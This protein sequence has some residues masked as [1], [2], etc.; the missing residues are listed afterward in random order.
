M[1]D[2]RHVPRGSRRFHQHL[3]RANFNSAPIVQRAVWPK[4]WPKCG[5]ET[6]IPGAL[7]RIHRVVMLQDFVHF[8]VH[9]LA[10]WVRHLDQQR[11]HNQRLSILPDGRNLDFSV[12]LVIFKSK[13]RSLTPF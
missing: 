12:K 7:M 11:R 1:H 5:A 3:G 8:L 13:F 4:E 2:D 9:H 6:P 10:S